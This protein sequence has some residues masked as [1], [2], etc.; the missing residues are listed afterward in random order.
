VPSSIVIGRGLHAPWNEGTRVIARNIGAAVRDAGHESQTISLSNSATF[1]T[2][3]ETPNL[4][5]HIPSRISS[6]AS[7][8]AI[9]DYY[10]LL[11][12]ARAI[13]STKLSA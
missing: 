6:R 13:G 12:T 11:R 2:G 3:D 4:V 10:Y 1:K 9:S 5:Y 8:A 7:L